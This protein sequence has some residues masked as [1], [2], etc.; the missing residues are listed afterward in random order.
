[1]GSTYEK[2]CCW[3]L[4]CGTNCSLYTIGVNFQQYYQQ[5]QQQQQQYPW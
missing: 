3:S 2:T 4:N 5:Q 1:M